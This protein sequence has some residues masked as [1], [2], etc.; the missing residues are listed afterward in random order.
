[1][2]SLTIEKGELLSVKRLAAEET[3]LLRSFM[4][5]YMYMYI[6]IYIYI[7]MYIYYIYIYIYIIYI[8]IYIAQLSLNT[9]FLINTLR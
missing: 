6:Y 3:L 9:H 8:Y 1:M 4:Y 7:Y 2:I 5:V